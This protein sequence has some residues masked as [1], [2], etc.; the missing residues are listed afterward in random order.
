MNLQD[1][2]ADFRAAGNASR[3]AWA[4]RLV[5]EGNLNGLIEVHGMLFEHTCEAC[6]GTV[7][8]TRSRSITCGL[9][10]PG[11]PLWLL[12]QDC[13]TRELRVIEESGT[14]KLPELVATY[15]A[16]KGN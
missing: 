15:F 1:R 16:T 6:G 10:R 9:D 14:N 11:E 13:R 7:P 12:C 8:P 4:F 3:L 2:L 5:E